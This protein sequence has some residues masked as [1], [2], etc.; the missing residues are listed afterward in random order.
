[1]AEI[2]RNMVFSMWEIPT[3]YSYIPMAAL[4]SVLVWPLIDWFLKNVN[5]KRN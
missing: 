5:Y 1:L 2:L 3:D 4:V